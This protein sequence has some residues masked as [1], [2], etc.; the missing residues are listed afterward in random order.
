[1]KYWGSAIANFD[2]RLLSNTIWYGTCIKQW[3]WLKWLSLPP[4]LSAGSQGLDW[5]QHFGSSSCRTLFCK[6]LCLACFWIKPHCVQLS[7][8]KGNVHSK[9]FKV[10]TSASGLSSLSST[11]QP[12]CPGA[13][14][15]SSRQFQHPCLF[16]CAHIWYWHHIPEILFLFEIGRCVVHKVLSSPFTYWLLCREHSLWGAEGK[17][18]CKLRMKKTTGFYS[19][20]FLACSY[21]CHIF[22]LGRAITSCSILAHTIKI[23]A[24]IG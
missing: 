18:P 9:G 5:G 16:M 2:H 21:S 24:H 22:I 12:E 3:V 23:H 14:L 13:C 19:R 4:T 17:L 20:S 10:H 8:K 7:R 6:D 1:M 11:D 15:D